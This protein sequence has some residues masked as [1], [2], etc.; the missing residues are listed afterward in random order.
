MPVAASLSVCKQ[1]C[2]KVTVLSDDFPAA[3]LEV[4]Q[5]SDEILIQTF[6][7]AVV[8]RY[9]MWLFLPQCFLRL[10]ATTVLLWRSCSCLSTMCLRHV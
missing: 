1:D 3:E 9:F 5:F 2:L 6:K 8:A 7:D 10:V 4:I